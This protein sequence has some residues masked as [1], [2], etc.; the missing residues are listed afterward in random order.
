MCLSN[1]SRWRTGRTWWATKRVV[2]RGVHHVGRAAVCH[3]QCDG[4]NGGVRGGAKAEGDGEQGGGGDDNKEGVKSNLTR[5]NYTQ[6]KRR[7]QDEYQFRYK[8]ALF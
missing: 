3:V 2:T 6:C 4:R 1:C 5:K 7:C 8:Y